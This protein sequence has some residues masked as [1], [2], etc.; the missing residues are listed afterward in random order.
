MKK[1]F[2]IL[3]LAFALSMNA[4]AAKDLVTG[5]KVAA[6]A[7]G[8]ATAATGKHVGGDAFGVV[9]FVVGGAANGVKHLAS[10]L[11]IKSAKK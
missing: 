1:I 10:D 2:V 6:P 3:T 4:F 8:N 11:H 7:V 5:V 9:R